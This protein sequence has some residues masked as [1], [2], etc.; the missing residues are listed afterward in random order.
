M[1]AADWIDRVKKAHGVTSDYAASAILETSRATISKYRNFVTP[2]LDETRCI[3]IA[4]VLGISPS[5]VVLDQM[6]ERVHNP[7]LRSD[8]LGLAKREFRA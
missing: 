4:S 8:L 7:K 2:T 5:A 3:K 6:A 1:K